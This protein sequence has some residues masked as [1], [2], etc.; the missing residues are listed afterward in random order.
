[1][2]VAV[3]GSINAG[4]STLINALLEEVVVA[5]GAV[6][7]TF[8]IN[9]L[10][11]GASPSLVVHF[12][13]KGRAP[14]Q[15]SLAELEKLTRRADDNHAYRLGIKYIEVF[16]PNSLLRTFH[17]IDTPGLRSYFKDDSQNTR[18]FMQLHGEELVADTQAEASKADAV[19]YLFSHSISSDDR[20]VLEQFQGPVMGYATPI[21]AIGVL[22]KMDTYWSDPNV[23]DP[24]E[25]AVRVVR[26]LSEHPQVRRRIYTISPVSCIVALGAKTIM[27]EEFATLVQL[28]G[29]PEDRL[30][31]LLRTADRF[32][33]REYPKEPAIPPA[34]ARGIVLERL[35]QY[36]VMLACSLI[37]KGVDDRRCLADELFD[38]SGVSG[39]RKLVISHFGNRAFL[40]KLD[41]VLRRIASICF[42]GQN[43]YAGTDRAIVGEIA[44]K[45]EEIQTREHAFLELK[46]LRSHY[47][48]K[49]GFDQDEVEQLLKV[50]GEHGASCGERLGLGERATVGEMVQVAEERRRYW[51]RRANDMFGSDAHTAEAA[52]EIARS[53]DWILLHVTEAKKH[54][55]C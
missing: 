29:L 52:R 55:Y 54:L 23:S 47:E 18:D 3:V 40:I 21:N 51:Q 42:Q 7:A 46:V 36:G 12:K 14:E 50:T 27:D 11:H 6:E 37:R 19:L 22:T 8:N 20:S 17:L 34:C 28:A 53:F 1:M 16:H 9:W 10:K 45:V 26:R 32:G 48:G 49:L 38:R 2:R 30:Q 13:Q 5:T 25:A 43:C 44:G 39:L 35:G 41:T 33:D 15:K 4:K 24:R 31:R